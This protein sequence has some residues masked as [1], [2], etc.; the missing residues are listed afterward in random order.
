MTVVFIDLIMRLLVIE[1]KVARRYLVNFPDAISDHNTTPGTTGCNGEV[2]SNDPEHDEQ[3]P[4]LGRVNSD[5]SYYRL[6][7]KKS[8]IAKAIPILP[9]LKDPRLLVALLISLVQAMLFGAFDATVPMVASEYFNFNS[10][11]A[12]LL[13]LPLG[14]LDLFMSPVFGWWVD[15]YGTKPVAVLSYALLVP[16]LVLLRVPTPGG[17]DQVIVYSVLLALCGFALGGIGAPSLVEAGAVVQKY[18]EV[19]PDFFGECGPYAQLYGLS[20]M[21]FSLGL[22][23]GPELAGE[24]K[25]LIGYGNMNLVLAIICFVTAILAYM[26]IGGKPR[27]LTWTQR[28]NRKEYA[29]IREDDSDDCDS[30]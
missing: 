10:L 19:N 1:K 16:V 15:R 29:S 6:S 3:T 24:L 11:K 26:Y 22:T 12:G 28:R 2:R 21:V 27:T 5:D 9:L 4:L 25:Q 17:L 20:N 23:V 8:G 18:Y 7:S 13:F 30:V 14:I